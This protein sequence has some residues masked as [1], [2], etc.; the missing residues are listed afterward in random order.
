M[1]HYVALSQTRAEVNFVLQPNT[2]KTMKE[3]KE[4]QGSKS[5]HRKLSPHTIERYR[6]EGVINST[7]DKR[8]PEQAPRGRRHRS[9]LP[10]LAR[11][12]T[13]YRPHVDERVDGK[14]GVRFTDPLEQ[15]AT[16]N[17]HPSLR[18]MKSALKKPDPDRQNRKQVKDEE[19]EKEKP[20]VQ[21]NAVISPSKKSDSKGVAHDPGF[22]SMSAS[23]NYE[24]TTKLTTAVASSLASNGSNVNVQNSRSRTRTSSSLPSAELKPKL[25]PKPKPKINPNVTSE[26]STATFGSNNSSASFQT[27]KSHLSEARFGSSGTSSSFSCPRFCDWA[28]CA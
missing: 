10:S 21:N 15:P 23:P 27:A 7:D 1:S 26:C 18:K 20:L 2:E 3:T 24:R 11:P 6:C 5:R 13:P 19:E 22:K 4:P 9:S 16:E 25:K 17:R 28:D 14:K 12:Q 8:L